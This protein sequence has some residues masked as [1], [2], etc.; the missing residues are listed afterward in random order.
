M[1]RGPAADFS[2]GLPEPNG[3]LCDL[4]SVFPTILSAF[5]VPV[6][7]NQITESGPVAAVLKG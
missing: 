4:K 7:A 5:E 2:T 6:P 3:R 1:E